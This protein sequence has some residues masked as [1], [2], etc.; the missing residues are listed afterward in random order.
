MESDLVP[1]ERTPGPPGLHM[2]VIKAINLSDNICLYV[3]YTIFFFSFSFYIKINKVI[4]VLE[5][6]IHFYN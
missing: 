4:Q 1:T 5:E 3:I 2:N 6:I